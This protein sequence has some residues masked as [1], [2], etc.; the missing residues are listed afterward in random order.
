MQRLTTIEL[1]KEYLNFSAAHFTVFSATER[2]RLHGH[3]FSVYA[4][5][6]APVT[7]NGM[8]ADYGLFK[9]KLKA[10]CEELDEYTLIAGDSPFLDIVQEDNEIKVGFGDELLRFPTSD[11]L[12]LPILNTT[13]EEFSHYLLQK[14]VADVDIVED[15]FVTSIVVKV[16]S[17]AGQFGSAE[18]CRNL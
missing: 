14:L 10:L 8:T 12:V 15:Y 16:S 9:N 11:C 17:G 5:I 6:T 2:E 18:W 4:A 7:D 3:N 1:F 13:V